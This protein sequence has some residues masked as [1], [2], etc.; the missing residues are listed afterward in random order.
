MVD[1]YGV[2]IENE[3]LGVRSEELIMSVVSVVMVVHAES[4]HAAL[5]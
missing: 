2:G 4:C 3:E 1:L 5:S